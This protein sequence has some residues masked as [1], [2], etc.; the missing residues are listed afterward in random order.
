M[1]KNNNSKIRVQEK[2]KETARIR[3]RQT[4][5]DIKRFLGSI[6]FAQKTY[7]KINNIQWLMKTLSLKLW[8]FRS[9]K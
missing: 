1:D 6:G 5:K 8:A 9:Q 7:N 4:Y 2:E 3:M